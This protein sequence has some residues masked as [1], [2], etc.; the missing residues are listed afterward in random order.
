MGSAETSTNTRRPDPAADLWEATERNAREK[1]NEEEADR[2]EKAETEKAAASAQKKLEDAEAALAA[3]RRAEE[4][5]RR[6]SVMLV[7]PLLSAPPPPE[8]TGQTGE[9]GTENPVVEKE[10]GEASMSDTAVPPPPPPPPSGR[11][12]GKQP[13]GPSEPPV[14]DEAV[15][16]LLL[17]VASPVR[18]RL[19][20]ATSAPRPRETGTASSATLDVKASS[21][22]PTGWL[23]GRGTGP[24]N[25]ALLD[26]QVKLRAESDALQVCTRAHLAARTSVR[27]C[28]L[29]LSDSCS[30]LGGRASAPTGCSPRVPGRL[31]SRRFG[32]SF[33]EFQTL[34]LS[35][36]IHCRSITT[37]TP[38]PSTAMLRS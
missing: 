13:V 12:H 17:Q 31:L 32:T 29:L 20:R 37:S 15:A 38:L 25:Q 3:R 36:M 7:P 35:S 27:V 22:A 8:F 4:A 9:A 23:R 26:V 14:T 18:R 34:T 11:P 10:S 21:A 5:A 6:R 28:F 2:R 30:S 16:R 1:H 24:L 19:E 33:G